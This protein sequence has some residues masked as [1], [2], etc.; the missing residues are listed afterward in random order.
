[1]ANGP[2]IPAQ[3]IAEAMAKVTEIILDGLHHGFFD[4][5]IGCEV[6]TGQKRI[7]TVRSGKS[8]RFIVPLDQIPEIESRGR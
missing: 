2:D 4:V 1:M 5:T 6:G 7:L 8:Y 3:G